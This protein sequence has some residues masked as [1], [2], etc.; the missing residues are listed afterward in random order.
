MIS[1]PTQSSRTSISYKFNQTGILSISHHSNSIQNL[2]RSDLN[3]EYT[4]KNK[5]KSGIKWFIDPFQQCCSSKTRL[6]QT[7]K[8]IFDS[9]CLKSQVNRVNG[10][11]KYFTFGVM[12]TNGLLGFVLFFIG[13][14]SSF[15]HRKISHISTINTKDTP[16][17]NPFNLIGIILCIV[18]LLFFIL[19]VISCLG[20]NREN[21]NLLRISLI[22]QFL[23]L[24]IFLIF[25]ITILIW[26]GKIRHKIA[27]AMMIGLKQYYH[28]DK[29]WTVFFD[30]L[31][32]NYFC[33]G[34][35][36]F[37]D[38]NDNP[39]YA[40][41][42]SNISQSLDACS[43]PFTCCKTEQK[44]DD[45]HIY[46]KSL[47]FTCGMMILFN[48]SIHLFYI[49]L[50]GINVLASHNM[51]INMNEIQE[52]ININGCFDEILPI[53]QQLIITAAVFMLLICVIIFITMFLT[54]L[55]TF[56]IRLTKSDVKRHCQKKRRSNE[57]NHSEKEDEEE[58][59]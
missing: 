23:T 8:Y 59:F 46:M 13:L 58:R 32:L 52:R 35:Y 50:I 43:I 55:L 48:T 15:E 42:S 11:L 3:I 24:I 17:L 49:S 6:H 5:L 25:S 38:W 57:E 40:C 21:L 27:D 26:G 10:L 37:N 34:V 51:T 33:C 41:I 28:I 31:H 14:W 12:F 1:T 20:I 22:G 56:D 29:A 18:G 45:K 16:S 54:C 4:C 44:V 9:K 47:A 7:S 19:C 36:S 53:I 2:S 30:K 39:N